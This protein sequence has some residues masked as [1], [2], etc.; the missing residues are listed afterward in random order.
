MSLTAEIRK[1]RPSELLLT[2]DEMCQLHGTVTEQPVWAGM[3]YSTD[4]VNSI[5]TT[6]ANGTKYRGESAIQ[7]RAR[8][9]GGEP[10]V[11]F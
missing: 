3:I 8:C 7:E 4:S 2:K 6:N 9:I 10:K 11:S 1:D 5:R